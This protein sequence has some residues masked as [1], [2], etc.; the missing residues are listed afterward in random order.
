M[1]DPS[2]ASD[3]ETLDEV[4]QAITA[5]AGSH[6]MSDPSDSADPNGTKALAQVAEA[7][8]ALAGSRRSVDLQELIRETALNVLILTHIVSNLLPDKD[9]KDGIEEAVDQLVTRLRH[10]GWTLLSPA[11]AA[12]PTPAT[13]PETDTGAA[14]DTATP[15]PAP[16]Q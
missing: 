8:T 12:F 14:P 4:D 3:T 7:I 15:A 9:L 5:L 16:E 11:A 1:S 10:A 13:T 6:R 2:D